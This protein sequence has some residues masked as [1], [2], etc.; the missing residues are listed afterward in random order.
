MAAA[1]TPS[2]MAAAKAAGQSA[3]SAAVGV[4]IRRLW[5][6]QQRSDMAPALDPLLL[7]CLFVCF[8]C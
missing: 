3:S 6:T 8:Y 4:G 7:F 1:A 2:G 5:N